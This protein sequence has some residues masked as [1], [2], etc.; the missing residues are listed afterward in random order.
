M[1]DRREVLADPE[2]PA[3][4]PEGVFRE[5]PRVVRYQDT[6]DPEA[7][8]Y[9]LPEEFLNCLPRDSGQRLRFHPFCEVVDGHHEVFVSPESSRKR[10]QKVYPSVDKAPRIVD[11]DHVLSWLV[12]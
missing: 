10:S 8:D 2:L 3:P 11:G 5:L 4:A 1:T 9:V 6:R 7:A 12:T